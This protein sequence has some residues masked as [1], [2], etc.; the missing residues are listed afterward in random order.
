MITRNGYPDGIITLV[1]GG[2]PIGESLISDKRIKLVSF[3]GSTA[4]GRH[5]SQVVHN[6]FGRIILELGGNNAAIVTEDADFESALRACVLDALYTNAE[7]CTTL[8]R[9]LVQEPIYEK[10]KNRVLAAYATIKIGDPLN[11]ENFFGPLHT[12]AAVKQFVE[13]I[14]KIKEQGGKVLIGG[15]AIEG[16]GFY[17]QPTVVEIEHDAP[18]V[19]H[20]LFLP[21][22]YLIKFSTLDEAIAINNEVSQGLSSALFSLNMRHMWQWLGPNGSDC[23]L[24]NVNLSTSGEEMGGA[25]GGE[26]E[27]GEGRESGSDSWKL[28]MR[29]TTCAI[30]YSTSL[31]LAQGVTFN[32]S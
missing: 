23:G 21:I 7:R 24:A 17:V 13:S 29:R 5:V 30:N 3:T 25:F 28:Y 18:I 6:R 31:S 20:E 12:A 11:P 22:L 14:E 16:P 1:N 15:Q 27:T 26:K 10:F 4:V 32:I 2:V 9:L 8:R 19:Q